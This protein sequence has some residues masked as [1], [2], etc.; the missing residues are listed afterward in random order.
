MTKLIIHVLVIVA[1]MLVYFNDF[2][3]LLNGTSLGLFSASIIAVL[4]ITIE[5]AT[6]NYGNILNIIKSVFIKNIRLSCAYL[7]VIKYE[8]KYLLVKNNHRDSFQLVG[9]VFKRNEQSNAFL[10]SIEITED[11]KLPTSG[12]NK[13]DLRLYIKGKHLSKFLNWYNTKKEREISYS[14]EFYEELI[15]P[16]YLDYNIFPYPNF[17]YKKQIIT[18]IIKKPYFNCYEVLIYDI[19][20]LSLNSKQNFEIGKL[21]KKGNTDNIKWSDIQTIRNEGYNSTS[22]KTDYI[23][24]D[25]TKWAID[26]KYYKI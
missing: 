21:F 9:G 22:R 18:P 10:N 19:V 11:D 5:F 1:S 3:T 6:N 13:N 16:S 2:S 23:I 17:V 25:H 20:E 4:I 15:E 7:Y 12:R 24:G 14:R 26:K 8:D